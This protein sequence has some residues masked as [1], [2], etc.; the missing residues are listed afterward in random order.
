MAKKLKKFRVN[1]RETSYGTVTVDA[2]DVDDATDKAA[3]ALAEGD[4]E[5]GGK[6]D[7]QVNEE[8]TIRYSLKRDVPNVLVGADRLVDDAWFEFTVPA[9]RFPYTKYWVE[10]D[11]KVI[12]QREGLGRLVV[13]LGK[14]K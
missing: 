2:Y 6:I 12:A 11:G 9:D 13:R 8:F 5:W 10:V 7:Q 14:G 3:E 1:V 4:V